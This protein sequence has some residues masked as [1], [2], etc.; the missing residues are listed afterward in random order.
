[1]R[2]GVDAREIC[3]QSTG[4]GRWLGRLLRQW[5][6]AAV[7]HDVILYAPEAVPEPLG[8]GPRV[9]MRVVPGGRG[10]AWEQW[11]LP[12]AAATDRLDV[13]FAPAY[14]APLRL[15]VPTV[16][17]IHDVSFCAHPEWFTPRE[18]LRRRLLTRRTARVACTVITVS[19]FSRDE[20]VEHL[21]VPTSRVRVVS[22]GI[23]PPPPGPSDQRQPRALYVGSIFNRR[24]VPDL[25][26]AFGPIARRH[27]EA[28]LDIVGDNRTYPVQDVRQVIGREGLD[29][30]VRWHEYVTEDQL[31]ALYRSA[32]AFAFLSTYEGFGL[33]PLEALAA[34]VPSILLDTP[35]ARESC[36]EAALYAPAGDLRA[37]TTALERLLF[38]E[39]TRA[40]VLGAAP[41]TL[42]RYD[43]ARAAAEVMDTLEACGRA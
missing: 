31:A 23:D 13:F 19:A 25:V 27:P 40:S 34:G 28:S 15:R 33:T 22:P 10:S 43:W 9:E 36:G 14:T 7:P 30:C 12:R 42:A 29:Q 4:V 6:A 16:A 2:I 32:R 39:P 24:H 11:H 38:D 26:R 35:V 41:R 21:G 8:S 20:I 18:G 1:M 5:R 37:I 3:G 17:L